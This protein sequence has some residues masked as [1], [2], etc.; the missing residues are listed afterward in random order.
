[1]IIDKIFKHYI[2]KVY[3]DNSPQKYLAELRTKRN[4]LEEKLAYF[5]K[6]IGK[7][8][9]TVT[10]ITAGLLFFGVSASIINFTAQYR[11]QNEHYLRAH[12]TIQSGQFQQTKE[13]LKASGRSLFDL[14]HDESEEKKN[15]PNLS[16]FIAF[17]NGNNKAHTTIK[18]L[19]TLTKGTRIRTPLKVIGQKPDLYLLAGTEW[20]SGF[21][22]IFYEGTPQFRRF[23]GTPKGEIYKIG[24]RT[25]LLG[26][27]NGFFYNISI[28]DTLNNN[29]NSKPHKIGIEQIFEAGE[30][31]SSLVSF[32]FTQDQQDEYYLMT[33]SGKVIGINKNREIVWELKRKEDMSND[34]LLPVSFLK[35]DKGIKYIVTP[36]D[37]GIKAYDVNK[38][39]VWINDI[40]TEKPLLTADLDTELGEEVIALDSGNLFVLN[41][42]GKTIKKIKIKPWGTASH[43]GIHYSVASLRRD[44]D[45][46]FLFVGYGTELSIFDPKKEYKLE[47]TIHTEHY[48][49]SNPI[50]LDIDNNG[51]NEIILETGTIYWFSR[52]KGYVEVFSSQG[53]KRGFYEHKS[54]LSAYPITTV[55]NNGKND[56]LISGRYGTIKY[57]GGDWLNL[58][59]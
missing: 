4:D 32:R 57:L 43:R 28:E 20:L 15:I 23:S 35:T 8:N 29:P 12:H 21:I 3:G 13:H 14:I 53:K 1:M 52:D 42:D 22:E 50:I 6:K 9:N 38:K 30:K 31:S 46:K 51:D 24:E 45:K 2:A 7:F 17:N 48:I 47:K 27:V 58:K 26:T 56:F 10:V 11:K 5:K 40:E 54:I 33:G 18:E 44:S 39:E 55:P 34:N 16:K 36:M 19:E 25:Y 41:Q 59:D 49:N 37:N